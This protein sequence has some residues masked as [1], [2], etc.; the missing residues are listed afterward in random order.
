[1]A[2]QQ[3]CQGAAPA[4]MNWPQAMLKASNFGGLSQLADTETICRLQTWGTPSQSFVIF[5]GSSRSSRKSNGYTGYALFAETITISERILNTC[6]LR[7]ARCS[8]VTW[9]MRRQS[10]SRMRSAAAHTCS[11]CWLGSSKALTSRNTRGPHFEAWFLKTDDFPKLIH[12]DHSIGISSLS[13]DTHWSG[14]MN[15]IH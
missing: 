5:L 13:H 9:K 11:W 7:A 8:R 1:M 12:V 4:T 15:I 14:Q 3:S 10:D 6:C 2:T